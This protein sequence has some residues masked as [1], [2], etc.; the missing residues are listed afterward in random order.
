[1][2]NEGTRYCLRWT[3]LSP[4][5]GIASGG[6]YCLRW[7]V[8][9]QDRVL[10]TK[11]LLSGSNCTE[12]QLKCRNLIDEWQTVTVFRQSVTICSIIHSFAK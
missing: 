4:V 11:Y 10:L 5:D 1:V 8:L 3:V 7:M 6:C 9:P 12:W 2:G